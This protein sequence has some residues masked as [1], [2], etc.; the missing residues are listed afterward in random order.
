ML[1]NNEVE[2]QKHLDLH[3]LDG[4]RNTD[5]I[6]LFKEDSKTVIN[7]LAPVDEEIDYTKGNELAPGSVGTCFNALNNTTAKVIIVK[8]LDFSELTREAVDERVDYLKESVEKVKAIPHENIINYISVTE[9]DKKV[10][11]IMEY[12]PGGSLKFILNNF[13]KFKEKLIRIYCKQ[14]LEGLKCLHKQN[15]WHGDI[16]CSNLLIDDLGIVKLSDFA[17]IKRAFNNTSKVA[18]LRKFMKVDDEE[19]K[20]DDFQTQTLP[21]I[22]SECYTPPEVVK[23]S[24]STMNPA[25]DIWGLGW[26]IV[27][28]LTGKEPWFEFEGETRAVLKNLKITTAQPMITVPISDDCKDFLN[29]C[30]KIDPEK[31]KSATELLEHPFLSM[32]EKEV[33][34]SLEASNFISF[35]SI[36]ASQKSLSD[37]GKFRTHKLFNYRNGK[38]W[39]YAYWWHW[40]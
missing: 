28:M 2:Y 21:L 1:V 11:L 39:R 40:R 27:E 9:Q 17:F 6:R 5:K 4:R 36:L 24:K 8:T 7:G 33:K 22:G 34:E 15:I 37:H 26:A 13:T 16:K 35:F 29:Q 20:E 32:T 12:V 25:Y 18:Y 30:F 14:I 31:R 19:T 10:D 3:I 38:G 23:D